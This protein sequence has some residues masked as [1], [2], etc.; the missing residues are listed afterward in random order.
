MVVFVN[1]FLS[2]FRNSAINPLLVAEQSQ[3][4]VV[5]VRFVDGLAEWSKALDLGSSSKER[6]FKSHSRQA[7]F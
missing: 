6:G 7:Y 3:R 2:H 1:C 4:T 5:T